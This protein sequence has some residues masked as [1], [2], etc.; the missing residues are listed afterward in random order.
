MKLSPGQKAGL[1]EFCTNFSVAWLTAGIV[2][3]YI[4]GQNF[5]N[6]WQIIVISSSWAG[7]FLTAMLSLTRGLK[8]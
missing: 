5:T 2:G 8:Q 3:P 6:S 4:S 1:A 7:F